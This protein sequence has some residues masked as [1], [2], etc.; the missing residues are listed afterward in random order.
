MTRP[1]TASV[2]AFVGHK[3][4][5]LT[6]IWRAA[7]A[8]ARPETFPG[9]LDGVVPSFFDACADRLAREA[10]PEEVW[11]GLCG[12][13]RW[14]PPLAAAEVNREW[15]LLAE[16]IGAVCE[17]LN[18][19]AEVARWLERAASACRDGMAAVAQRGAAAPA[20]LVLCVVHSPLAPRRVPPSRHGADG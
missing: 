2:G 9:L 19:R 15:T 14:P 11:A 3:R 5:E 6:R 20:G 16:V 7:R 18:C 8:S 4:D 17:S 10:P 1:G 13:V 12:L